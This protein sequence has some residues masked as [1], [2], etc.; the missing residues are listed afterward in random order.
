[1]RIPK[2]IKRF[3]NVGRFDVYMHGGKILSIG[4][5]WGEGEVLSQ[6][7]GISRKKQIAML[8]WLESHPSEAKQLLGV[9]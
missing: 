1:M 5:S 8:D 9:K 4:L 2:E 6:S 3:A 7:Y